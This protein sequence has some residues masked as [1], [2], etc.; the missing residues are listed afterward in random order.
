MPTHDS[1]PHTDDGD[2]ELWRGRID[3]LDEALARLLSERLTIGRRIGRIKAQRGR[4]VR[5]AEREAEVLEHVAAAAAPGPASA[6]V[7]KIFRTII[8]ET[9]GLELSDAPAGTRTAYQGRPG[10]YS[11][12]AARAL[13]GADV[14][15]VPCRTLDEVIESLLDGTVSQAVLAIENSIA[16]EV[17]GARSL[18]QCHALAVVGEHVESID[19]VIAGVPSATLDDVRSLWSHPVA[20]AQ[21]RR[22]LDTHPAVEARPTFDT[23][24]AV[25]MVM[26]AGDPAQAALA[27]R[28]AATIYGAAVIAERVQDCDDNT[29]RFWLVR[30]P[31]DRD[32]IPRLPS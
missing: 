9:A 8:N 18:V 28:R 24:G 15:L 1:T 21:C 14:P 23:A 29:T 2:L 31:V 25:E 6:T 11:E 3:R 20:L 19:H 10:A 32:R 4:P 17:P 27:S 16:G 13:A 26:Q 5:E 22:F 7:R 30:L 12:S